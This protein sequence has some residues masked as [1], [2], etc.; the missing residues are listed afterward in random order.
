MTRWP[1]HPITRSKMRQITGMKNQRLI[2]LLAPLVFVGLL[3]SFGAAAPAPD[4]AAPAVG[5]KAG[6]ITALLPTA[7]IIRGEG[8]KA[9]TTDAARG[10]DV[11]WQDLVTTDKSGRAR[12]TLTDQ[13]ILSL[14]SQAQLRIVKHD[15]RAQQT[16]LEMTYGRVRAQVSTVTRDG[17]SF[18]LRTPT[19][20][21]GVIGTD[22][23][24]DASEPGV[25]TFLCISGL[26]QVSNADIVVSG[27]VP[28]AAGQTTTVKSG[29]P[30]TPPKPATP[31]QINKLITDTEPATI[32][33]FAP[34]SALVGTTVDALATGTHMAGING[35]NI[36]GAGVQVSLGG[37]ASETSAT[38]HLVIAPTAQPGPRTVTFTKPNGANTAAVFTVIAPPGL[39]GTDA[40]SLK[41]RYTDILTTE[42]QA[43]D[44]SN[45]SIKASLQQQADQG[46]QNLQ[47]N[48]ARLPQPLPSDPVSQQLTA[49]V[50][51]FGT[52]NTN[53]ETQAYNN[54]AAAIDQIVAAMLPK[55][56][57]GS[58]PT[59]NIAADLD[60]QFVPINEAFQT[61]LTQIHTDLTSLA[62]TQ[63]QL[64]DQVLANF[65]QAI[66]AAVQQQ[67][68]P[69]TPKVDVQERT[70]EAGFQTS[71]DASSSS[72]LLGAAITGTSWVLCDPSYRPAQV[73]VLLPAN[74]AGCRA[75]PGFAA[76]GGQFQFNTCTLNPADYI[77]RVTVVDS[78]GK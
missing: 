54:A 69:P 45:G 38:A 20:V 57:D 30:P 65:S 73:G 42:L 56:Q 47:Q 7:H 28:C 39:Q 40:A 52:T 74:A 62:A 27:S 8:K 34:A 24:T 61:S 70:I 76:S 12:I 44:S 9:V 36:G 67:L 14:G 6:K 49:I 4:T 19:A 10:A 48:D 18:Q 32:S 66:A 33:A 5:Q 64:I 77:A 53:R 51:N 13:S 75:I 59:A 3:S 72:A 55:I 68:A 31:Q 15:A 11:I 37:N 23:G 1:D 71:F 78:N 41:K 21:A 16:A 26:V 35:V 43:A 60:K 22:F 25:T 63:I 46:L 2:R 58:E 50:A 29:L 17:G